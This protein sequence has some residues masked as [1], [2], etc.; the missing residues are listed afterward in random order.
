MCLFHWIL[1]LALSNSHTFSNYS[2]T[3]TDNK[4]KKKGKE[5]PKKTPKDFENPKRTTVDF[6]A[7]RQDYLERKKVEIGCLATN[8]LADA[9]N[10]VSTMQICPCVCV[11]VD[12]IL[13]VR[14]TVYDTYSQAG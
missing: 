1:I 8:Y 14:G 9:E 2:T 5:K 3:P 11:C 7:E 10:R 13:M 4:K 12:F 6:L